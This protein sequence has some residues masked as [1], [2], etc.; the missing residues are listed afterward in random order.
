[1]ERRFVRYKEGAEMYSMGLT[2][3]QELAQNA[4]ACYKINQLVLVNLDVL[5]EYLETFRITE[6]SF[7]K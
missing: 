2:K 7:Y 3:F 6:N 4:K 5:D 1:M